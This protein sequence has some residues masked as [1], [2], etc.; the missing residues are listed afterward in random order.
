MEAWSRVQGGLEGYGAG[1]DGRGSVAP[2]ASRCRPAPR[3]HQLA[4]GSEWLGLDDP[5]TAEGLVFVNAIGTIL[6]GDNVW[7]LCGQEKLTSGHTAARPCSWISPPRQSLRTI[8]PAVAG[9]TA[10][11]PLGVRWSNPWCGRAS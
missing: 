4:M 1:C 2:D 5:G 8:R 3:M 9:A 6:D 11:S 7:R 10:G